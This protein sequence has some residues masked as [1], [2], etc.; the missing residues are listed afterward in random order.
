M[1]AQ[2]RKADCLKGWLGEFT[3]W[4][5]DQET[6]SCLSAPG[7][8]RTELIARRVVSEALLP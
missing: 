7:K 6:R 3:M 2:P 4:L 8:A 5:P 1:V